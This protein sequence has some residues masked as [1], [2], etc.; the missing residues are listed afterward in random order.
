MD[1]TDI[2]A[3]VMGLTALVTAIGAAI[4]QNSKIKTLEKFICM[5]MP[6]DDRILYYDPAD[7]LQSKSRGRAS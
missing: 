2:G 7:A 1:F 3:V 6:C 4:K 5:R